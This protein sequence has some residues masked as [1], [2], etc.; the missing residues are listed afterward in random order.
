MTQT[1]IVRRQKVK[2]AT[3]PFEQSEMSCEC[4][5]HKYKVCQ[6]DMLDTACNECNGCMAWLGYSEDQK[7]CL[8]C[9]DKK[10]ASKAFYG[11]DRIMSHYYI[12]PDGEPS[13]NGIFNR[14]VFKIEHIG[15]MGWAEC[16]LIEIHY[17]YGDGRTSTDHYDPATHDGA[18]HMMSYVYK[19]RY[20]KK[21]LR[22]KVFI[23]SGEACDTELILR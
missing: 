4:L 15:K 6:K 3:P 9:N 11:H 7:T 17:K 12:T 21:N 14:Y 23:A 20:N 10:R 22:L 2:P 16:R 13:P 19:G 5:N 8:E 18:I 1:T